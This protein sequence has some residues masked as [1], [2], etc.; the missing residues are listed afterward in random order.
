MQRKQ[1]QFQWRRGVVKIYHAIK[2][3]ASVITLLAP[4]PL[5]TNMWHKI[6]TTAPISS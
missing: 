1:F 4:H 2:Y 6:L 5:S 3:Y